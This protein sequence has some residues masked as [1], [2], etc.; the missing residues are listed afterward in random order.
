MD[1]AQIDAPPSEIAPALSRMVKP[2][3]I[4][5]AAAGVLLLIVMAL[6]GQASRHATQIAK[7]VDKLNEADGLISN[8]DRAERTYYLTNDTA[9]RD[10]FSSTGG[11]L[12]PVLEDLRRLVRNDAQRSERVNEF[13]RAA[14]DWT[15]Q[16]QQNLLSGAASDHHMVGEDSNRVDD[17]KKQLADIEAGVT[18]SREHDQTTSGAAMTVLAL[19]AVCL[20]AFGIMSIR[21]SLGNVRTLFAASAAERQDQIDHLRKS[22]SLLAT[23]LQAMGD[24]VIAMDMKS[25]ITFI[26]PIALKLTGW[27]EA[28]AVGK[29]VAKVVTLINEKTGKPATMPFANVLND[30]VE[31]R[32]EANMLALA[33]DSTRR[34]VAGRCAPT[35][36]DR[37]AVNGVVLVIHDQTEGRGAKEALRSSEAHRET[38]FETALD[39][40]V[41][42]DHEGKIIEFNPAA[43]KTF[44]LRRGEALGQAVADLL[45]PPSLRERHKAG[46][47]R[48][49]KSKTG[50][51]IDKR[52]EL[53]ALRKDRG[54]FPIEI[55]ITTVPHSNP[56]VFTAFIRD[57]T[58]RKQAEFALLEA[59]EAA[60]AES[61]E[62]SI[63]LNNMSD[64]LRTPL[65]AVLG[66]SE[67]LQEEAAERTAEDMVRD[68][69]KIQE[70]GGQLLTLITDILDLSRIES[71]KMALYLETFEVADVVRDSARAIQPLLSKNANHLQVRLAN[72]VKVMYA[73]RLKVRQALINLISNS[74][75]LT[76]DRTVT[77]DVLQ[78]RARDG[79]RIVFR[80]SDTSP[81]MSEEDKEKLL[82]ALAATDLG[83]A[84]KYGRDGL[85]LVLARHMCEQMGGELVGIR[86]PG[87]PPTFTIRL[88]ARVAEEVK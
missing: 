57:I 7:T 61:Q 21:A 22:H 31:R 56:Q 80:L 11:Q 76:R 8:M 84:R 2:P 38:L 50:G 24:A 37:G 65:N 70:A 18:D 62:K 36:D 48:Y 85:G 26:N 32:L 45:V 60:E 42:M 35:W 81:G 27:D 66:Y 14:L 87:R 19:L 67:L 52:V 10:N 74:C 20:I 13:S 28:D 53:S 88:P 16:E 1:I 73:D 83:M 64:E 15:T 5:L 4:A 71:G 34:P 3:L 41:L 54:E 49:L 30:G 23:T 33:R 86:E 29:E 9:F 79:N 46:L 12:G 47:E 69:K 51:I 75:K 39:A 44:G 59:K 40:I 77:L 6:Q 72:D 58:E 63:F 78:E 68:L 82:E 43:E 55:T 17:L 25:R